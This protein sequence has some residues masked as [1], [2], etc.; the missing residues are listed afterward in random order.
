MAISVYF[1]NK[2]VVLPGAYATIASG[3]QNSPRTLDYGKCLIIDSGADNKAFTLG[4]VYGGG[5]GI[6]DTNGNS[7]GK[8]AIY[9]FTDIDSFRSFIKGG[10]YWQLA[11]ALFFPDSLTAGVTGISEL[12]FVRAAK[13]APAK[14]TLTAADEGGGV[15][16]FSPKDE[17][18]CANAVLSGGDSN[19]FL[20]TGYAYD[21]ISDPLNTGKF[22][23]RVFVGT[24]TGIYKE[25]GL[26][27]NE[28]SIT[29]AKP[30]LVIQ[31]AGC[32]NYTE[33]INWA[34]NSAAFNNSFTISNETT[35]GTSV[36]AATSQAVTDYDKNLPATQKA[37][38]GTTEYD[39]DSLN[40]VFESIIGLDASFVVS[41]TVTTDGTLSA[42]DTAILN[43]IN[44]RAK[45]KKT[46][47]I[48]AGKD[49][50][51]F[52]SSLTLAEKVNSSH[53]CV[54][55]GDVGM[56]S[57][58]AVEGYRWWGTAYNAYSMVGRLAGKVPQIPLTNKSIGVSKLRHQL[59]EKEQERALN[60]G[61]LVTVYNES[62]SKF[63]VLQGINTLQDNQVLF[64]NNGESFSIQF[65]RV[66]DQI[67][68]EL[69]VNSEIDLLSSE[70][71]VNANTLSAGI[72]KNW[73]VNYLQS[74]VATSTADNL[75]L[76]FRDVTV[77]K[78]A[79][80]YYVTYGI[81]V[82]NEINKIFFTGFVFNN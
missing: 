53:G 63:V 13:T 67:N 58:T 2:K 4:G 51:D 39:T 33:L 30:R 47:F 14:M 56:A 18:V 8:N 50:A 60:S 29:A 77:T 43:Y 38:G 64:T 10:M 24:F 12:Y 42:T 74:R 16:A 31:S 22:V 55:H 70:N 1:N 68:K 34:R 23:L 76:S 44:N 3:E 46:L 17:G 82:N 25:D 80:Y 81:V 40:A 75:I 71:G 57:N 20:S 73:T 62:T 11:N 7:N 45:F 9:R 48:V 19:G 79:D 59:N 72:L 6:M 28:V 26:P 37:T 15:F 35:G 32:S 65:M 36:L 66:V 41:D 61:V 69:V 54:V 49:S 5:M 52:Q 78:Q 21:V 27:Y